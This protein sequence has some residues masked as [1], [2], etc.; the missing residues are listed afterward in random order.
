MTD[1]CGLPPD[2]IMSAPIDANEALVVVP[3]P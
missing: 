3:S 2:A 1:P